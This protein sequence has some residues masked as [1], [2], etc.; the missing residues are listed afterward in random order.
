MPQ[1][2]RRQS[3]QSDSHSYATLE[4]RRFLTADGLVVANYQQG[5]ESRD[6]GWSY[7]T[8]SSSVVQGLE[9]TFES[10]GG[11]DD[12]LRPSSPGPESQ[13]L[14]V[15]PFGGH[16]GSLNKFAIASWTVDQAGVYSISDS[17]AAVEATSFVNADGIDVR[18]FVNRGNSLIY[19][20][21]A[22][23][24]QGYF[25][26]TLGLLN[27]GDEIRIA[28]GGKDNFAFDRYQTDFSI[29]FHEELGQ[30]LG[31]YSEA[32]PEEQ[33]WKLLWNAPTDFTP[34]GGDQK[35]GSIADVDSYQPLVANSSGSFNPDGTLERREPTWYLEANSR[36]GHV[37][38]GY[39]DNSTF[40]DRFVIAS[41][42]V[43]RSGTYTLANSFLNV[44]DFSRDG[45]TAWVYVKSLDGMVQQ[46]SVGPGDS[47][48]FDAKLGQLKR[49][50]IVYVA[51]GAGEN[52]IGDRFETDFELIRELPR[53]EPLRDLQ[54]ESVVRVSD[55]GAFANDRRND[56]DGF[57]AAIAAAKSTGV[58]TTILLENGIYNLF[59]NS[60]ATD[61]YLLVANGLN[62]V[63]IEGQGATIV[64]ENFDRGLLRIVNSENLILRN[65]TV[66]YAQLYHAFADPAQDEYRINTHSQGIISQ[67]DAEASSFV[68][69]V[70]P[71]DSVTPN[72]SFVDSPEV[73]AWGFALD[74][75]DGNRL[76]YNSRWHYATQ[77]IESLGQNQYRIFVDEVGGLEDGDRYVLQRRFNVSTFGIFNGS[78]QV[79]LD[80]IVSHSSPSTFVAAKEVGAINLIN[81]RVV[82]DGQRWR[83]I[84]ADAVHG[85]ALRTGFWV[86]DSNFDA[87]GD[88]VMNFY[89]VPLAALD[90]PEP[91]Q[92]TVATVARDRLVG[93]REAAVQVGDLMTFLD[94]VSGVVIQKARVVSIETT[95]IEDPLQGEIHTRTLTFDQDINGIRF[96][97]KAGDSDVV[98]YRDD[99]QIYNSTTSRGFLVQGTRL[100]N[101]RRYG[102]YLMAND[103]QLVDNTYTGL[104]D[105]AI[106]AHNETNWPIGLYSS[107]VLVHNN[108]FLL[109]GFSRPYFEDPYFAGVVAFHMDR[110]VDEFVE[111]TEFELSRITISDNTFRGWGKT[112][113]AVRNASNVS[114][115]GNAFYSPRAYPNPDRQDWVTMV[116]FSVA[117]AT[118]SR[119]RHR[120]WLRFA[121]RPRVVLAQF[122][123]NRR[124]SCQKGEIAVDRLWRI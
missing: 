90:Q 56:V 103:V 81:N 53:V 63:V 117:E 99:T 33:G 62:N 89:N 75:E 85:Q 60:N 102:N 42:N 7:L 15:T 74:G 49:G 80:N 19:E 122:A 110:L 58:P 84:N 38:V 111:E 5:F 30:S 94:P 124:K 96:G 43:A 24:D 101:S 95:T 123:V 109:S 12:V 27:S 47:G 107:N 66:D 54:T 69:T 17:F 113:I 13:F 61:I 79:T 37:G 65:F 93:V 6:S 108:R 76:K 59:A 115:T 39:G 97:S 48:S 45:V 105:S 36:G 40:E 9:A 77:S 1:H 86:E 3:K 119:S 120:F 8:N 52:H 118:R 64:V 87:V 55:Y 51:F 72:D 98:G 4:P 92:L 91:N 88:D 14:R 68:L 41:R 50:D 25:D 21:V 67:L 10:L 22:P 73:Q 83:S 23:G 16:A 34:G 31:K 29:R 112:A 114:I 121:S 71:N 20:E 116:V 35:T 28:F 44:G 2:F 70:D 82:T 46:I 100:A 106:A 11:S 18:V 32:S 104:S 57:T 26:T 78:W